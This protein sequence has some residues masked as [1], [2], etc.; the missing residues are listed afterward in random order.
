MGKRDRI[1]D[2]KWMKNA[3]AKPLVETRVTYTIA[4]QRSD[5][6]D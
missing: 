2:G 3:M 4:L 6:H 5:F 1:C